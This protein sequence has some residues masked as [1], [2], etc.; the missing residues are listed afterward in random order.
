M[1]SIAPITSVGILRAGDL[2]ISARNE[3]AR[4]HN[5]ETKTVSVE[6]ACPVDP[7][8]RS[9]AGSDVLRSVPL[10]ERRLLDIKV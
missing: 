1:T 8:T 7:A 4:Q 3:A 2:Q 9:Q 6:I 5:T 10:T